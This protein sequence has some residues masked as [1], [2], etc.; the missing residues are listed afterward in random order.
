MS[1]THVRLGCPVCGMLMA[2]GRLESDF[3]FRFSSCVYRSNG[4]GRG[5]YVWNHNPL[6]PHRAQLL[7]SL[8]NKLFRCIDALELEIGLPLES[9]PFGESLALIQ[10]TP[11]VRVSHPWPHRR[12]QPAPAVR[13]NPHLV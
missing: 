10:P 3:P 2:P 8:R 1:D 5:G 7:V 9:R 13:L 12:F 6:L 4:R 11:L